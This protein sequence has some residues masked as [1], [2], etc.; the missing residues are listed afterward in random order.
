M[1]FVVE[2]RRAKSAV[3][4]IEIFEFFA[5]GHERATVM[6][7]VRQFRRPQSSTSELLMALVEMGLLYRHIETRSYSPTPRLAELGRIGQ[8]DFIRDGQVY[9]YMNR[10]A[11]TTR[12][13]VGLFGIVG[14][15]VQMFHK[16]DGPDEAL[17]EHETGSSA[18]L[19]ASA[20][21]RLLLSTLPVAHSN[22]LLWRLQAEALENDRFDLKKVTEE[23]ALMSEKGCVTG[24]F[25]FSKRTQVTAAIIP[26]LRSRHRLAVGVIYP[27]TARIDATALAS[28]LKHGLTHL[29]DV[30]KAGPVD[31]LRGVS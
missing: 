20:V 6:D 17:M 7:I 13:E 27:D 12:C 2:P 22:G 29:G 31:L 26:D 8:P 25:G 19:S 1:T 15:R 10:L 16:I 11:Q 30:D 3:R 14:T 23:V 9:K 21:G 28:T 5:A 24:T 4:V 18:L